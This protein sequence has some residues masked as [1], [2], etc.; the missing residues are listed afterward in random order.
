M[1]YFKVKVYHGGWFTY[2]N[3]PLEYVGGET[4]VIEEI[5]GDRWSVFEAYAE[6]KQ[7]GYVEENIPSLWF[8][9]PVA[10]DMEKNLKLFKTDADSIEMCRIAELRDHVD[11]YVVH[12]VQDEEMFLDVGYIDVGDKDGMCDISEGQ[13]LV[14]YGGVDEGG[15]Q[16]KPFAADSGAED[17]NE[18]GY[19]KSSDSDSLDSEYNPSGEEDDSEDDVHFTDSDD[20]VDPEVSGF[21]DVNV[22]SKKPRAVNKNACA[23]EQFEN[24]EGGD[25]DDLDFD[26]QVGS[27]SEHEGFTFPVH[28]LQKDM[29]QYKWEVSTLYAS[30]DEFKDTVTAYAVHTARSIRFRKCDLQRVRAVCSGDCPFW[31]YAAKAFKKKVESNSKVKIKELVSKAQ[32]KWNLTVTKS[33]ATKTK[34]I[35]LDQIQE[36][37]REQY[38]IAIPPRYWSRSRFTYNSKVD[39]LVNNMSESFNSAIVDA[40]EKPIVTM[41]EEIRVKLMTR[42]AENRELAQNYLGTILPRIRFRLEKRSRSAGDWRP[43]WSTASKYEVVNGLEKF[44]VDLGSHECSCRIWQ[45][46]GIPCVHAISCIKFKGLDIEPFVAGCYKREAY[47]RCYDS[48]IHPLNGVDLWERTAHPDVMPPPYRR[49]SHRPVKKRRAAPGDEEQSSRTQLSRKGE[50]QRCSRC[51]SV[52][53]KRSRCPKP[54]EELQSKNKGKQQKGS[55]KTNHLPAKGG[56]K[57]ASSQP[58]RKAISATQ[59]PSAAQSNNAA[60]PKRPRGRPKGTTKSNSSTQPAPQPNK[61]ASPTSSAPPSSSSQPATTTIPSSQPTLTTSSSQPVSHFSARLSGAPHI[62]PKKL[63][64]MAKLP[65]RKWEML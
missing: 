8:K 5:D 16:S 44:A 27:D 22:M 18:V 33:L 26:H 15:K 64:L 34:Q 56:R 60:Q 2:K 29:S 13:E 17:D 19:D 6:L 43:Y 7:L 37:F 12:K 48:I 65:P 55:T 61:V 49:P 46:S 24:V 28:K 62:S 30:R 10:E 58:K 42:W 1:G 59:P 45:M 38:L 14:P 9:D 50:T 57:T 53:D 3:G 51:G 41:L 47:M 63:K 20:D 21:Q 54:I 31:V 32:K 35:A 52:G 40:R 25:S 23:N 4:T 36:T 11:L 39:T